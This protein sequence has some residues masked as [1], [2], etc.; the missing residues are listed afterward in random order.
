MGNQP[1][2]HNVDNFKEKIEGIYS[3][4]L[5]EKNL[6][7]TLQKD[8]CDNLRVVV[9]NDV[10][11]DYSGEVL[12][13]LGK[14]VLL[15]MQYEEVPKGKMDELSD[16]LSEHFVKKMNLVGT[17]ITVIRLAHVKLDRIK[18]GSFC[19]KRI[20]GE[21]LT[22]SALEPTNIPVRPTIPFQF[23]I[24]NEMI[25]LSD[26]VYNIR[27]QV[28]E[29][30]K[31]EG[32]SINEKLLHNLALIEIDNAEDCESAGGEWIEDR[33]KA[34]D[35]YLM[36]SE[37]L[38]NHNKKWFQTLE[39]LETTIYSKIS[40][41]TMSLDKLIE[42][43]VEPRMIDGKEVRKKFYRDRMIYDKDLD[44][45]LIKTKK[46]ISDLFLD[47]DS[48]YLILFSIRVVGKKH[49]DELNAL[50]T[51]IKTLKDEMAD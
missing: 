10:L 6:Y 21:Y 51:K 7:K 25:E 35:I 31:K 37:D 40:D 11:K 19:I 47:L 15:G 12:N 36:P 29:R 44:S 16:K 45:L 32:V 18:N 33:G 48:Y 17:I 3:Q 5:D 24:D 43:K 42:E 22:G 41:L 38:K 50:E 1:S 49:V 2:S 13:D 14:T 26:D 30:L 34:V 39:K 46:Q 4:V 20:G 28:M 9:V 8:Y 27:P 23:Q